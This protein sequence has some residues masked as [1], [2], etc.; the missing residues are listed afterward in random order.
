MKYKSKIERKTF[1]K[2]RGKWV[3]YCS[4]CKKRVVSTEAEEYFNCYVFYS[5]T[6]ALGGRT[7]SLSYAEKE[8]ERL[9][10]FIDENKDNIDKAVTST[11]EDRMALKNITN[12]IFQES[13][14][15]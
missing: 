2:N 15:I 1:R 4:H 12:N 14:N 6:R 5:Q 7:C 13:E 11:Y 10:K 8:V 9:C 3:F